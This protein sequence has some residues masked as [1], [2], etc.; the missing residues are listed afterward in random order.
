MR[1]LLSMAFLTLSLF[2]WFP[3]AVAQPPQCDPAKVIGPMRCAS[4]HE[5]EVRTWLQTPH[6]RTLEELHRRPEANAIAAKMGIRSIKR[7][8]VCLDCHYTSQSVGDKNQI[9][10][11]VSCES[12]HGAALDWVTL[13][14]D[15]GGPTALKSQESAANK[16]KRRDLS[17]AHG[18]RNPSNVYLVARSCLQCHSVP[19]EKL[20]NVGGHGAGNL[21]FELVSWSQG[22]NRHNF[23]RTE[24]KANAENSPEAIRVMFVAGLIA[25]LEFSTRAVAKATERGTYGLTVANR[26]A[27]VAMR[28]KAIQDQ[29]QDPN[30][31]LALVAFSRVVL[32]TNN[33]IEL[34]T[35]ADEIQQA[36]TA[37]AQAAD[38]H[39]LAALDPMIPGKPQYK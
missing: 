37:F 16:E 18:M 6:A 22:I 27:N 9:I 23:L 33:E 25:D 12:C 24:N 34:N 38:G 11:G 8:D 4:C 3:M 5:N 35:I 14:N 19:N 10:A 31:E 29:I 13:H 1:N 36:G 26:A 28:L 15:Y 20:V 21:E 30:L 7:G 17:I 2:C 32:K 39:K